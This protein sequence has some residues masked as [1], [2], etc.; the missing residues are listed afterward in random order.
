MNHRILLTG[1]G[2]AGSVT[3]LIA[4]AE[5]IKKRDPHVEFLF[6]GTDNGPERVLAETAGI[7]FRAIPAGKLRRYWSWQNISDG[8]GLWRGFRAARQIIKSWRP[9]II[10]SAGSYVSV[11]VAW[12]GH[13][14]GCK[15]L[16][17]QQ[18]VRPGLANRLMTPAADIVTVTFPKSVKDFPANKVHLTGNPVRPAVLHG[19]AAR[20]E[21]IFHLEPDVPV[22]V[23][24]GGGTGSNFLNQITAV[25]VH[26]LI[27]NWQIIH[28]TGSNRKFIELSD[29]RYHRFEFLTADIP[30]ALAA[31]TVVVSRAG[32]GMM[33]ELAALG[34]AT[35][36]VPMPFTH[37]EE[38]AQ[39]L[40]ERQA[41][42]VVNQAELSADRL[43]ALVNQLLDHPD[44][45]ASLSRNIH[46]LY[47]PEALDEI[48]DL[49]LS[50]GSKS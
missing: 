48:T 38:N 6:V 29:P 44:Q 13:F 2:T 18:D 14:A 33:T 19:S 15:V 1:G 39:Y 50:L 24:A 11:P 42:L 28:L 10:V 22:L 4:I 17:H 30:H 9:Q 25:A 20:A 16:V 41:G 37:Q 7:P 12:A 26:K 5:N 45:R 49:V 35:I 31:A 47:R 27:R 32:L 3:S 46:E 8:G 43:V 36:F 23:I 40:V 34:K 21:E